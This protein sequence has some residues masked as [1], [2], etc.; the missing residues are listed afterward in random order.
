M[1]AAWGAALGQVQ[2][3]RDRFERATEQTAEVQEALRERI[4]SSNEPTLAYE[5]TSGTTAPARLVPVTDQSLR[6]V[7]DAVCVW[8]DD[9]TC[10][11]PGITQGRM[12]WAI[13]PAGRETI[14]APGGLPVG[15]SDQDWLGESL[16]AVFAD[17]LVVPDAGTSGGIQAWQRATLES[18]VSAPDLTFVS[19]WSPTFLL[20]LLDGL[21][22]PPQAVWP[23]L[24]TVSCWADGTS[25]PWARSLV[26]R[27]PPYTLVQP[28]GLWATEGVVTLPLAASPCPV[29]AVESAFF[30]FDGVDGRRRRAHELSIGDEYQVLLTTFGGLRSFSLGDRVRVEGFRNTAPLLRFVGRDFVSDL[31]GEKLSE[32]F[33]AEC[34]SSPG[35]SMLVPCPDPDPHYLVVSDHPVALG[36]LEE[37]LRENP[38]YAYARDLGQLGALQLRVLPDALDRYCE[39]RMSQGARLGDIKPPALD[40]A[41]DGVRSW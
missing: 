5:R 2:G 19:V 17:L 34:L 39:Y 12:Y 18:L 27:L 36:S 23:I 1:K 38:H 24:D 9:L 13:S 3:A 30:E 6:R 15:L 35:F 25:A 21:E 4:V 29:L 10:S 16:T 33:V 26:S 41:S 32:P 8:L 20:R 37:R 14:Q 11:R 7:R 22:R 28:K 31:V 40:R